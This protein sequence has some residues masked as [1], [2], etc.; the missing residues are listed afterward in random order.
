LQP[1]AAFVLDDG[2]RSAVGYLLGCPNTRR[3]AAMIQDRLVP[4]LDAT[5]DVPPPKPGSDEVPFADDPALWAQQE[6]Y[7]NLSDSSVV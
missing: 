4:S 6:L 1:G 5:L 7:N 2:T 3:F